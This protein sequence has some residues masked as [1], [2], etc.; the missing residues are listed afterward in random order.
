MQSCN[1]ALLIILKMEHTTHIIILWGRFLKYRNA[2]VKN[3]LLRQ[4]EDKLRRARQHR[5]GGGAAKK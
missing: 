4:T 1:C 5:A 2:A 3:E